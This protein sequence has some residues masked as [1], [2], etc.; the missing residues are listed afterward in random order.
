MKQLHV[1]EPWANSALR[2]GNNV[3]DDLLN[4]IQV[5]ETRV[6]ELELREATLAA[7]VSLARRETRPV[8]TRE[9]V[10]AGV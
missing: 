5:L 9:A 1:R 8:R 10:P 2:S 3:L 7:E 4:R 6:R